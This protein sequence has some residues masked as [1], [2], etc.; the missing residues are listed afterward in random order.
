MRIRRINRRAHSRWPDTSAPTPT[1]GRAGLGTADA[2]VRP[3]PTVWS[4]LEYGCHVRDVH[5]IF[6]E[7]VGLMLGQNELHFSNWDQDAT[8]LDG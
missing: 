1:N 5:R 6:N 2:T 7:R 3:R 4:A 8:A